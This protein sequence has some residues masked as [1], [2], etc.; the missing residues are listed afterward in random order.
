MKWASWWN[1]HLG[2]MGILGGTGILVEL[3]SWWN[4]HLGGTG[5]LPVSCLFSRGQ[6]AHSTSIHLKTDATPFFCLLS[7]AD[8][9]Q[10]RILAWSR[11]CVDNSRFHSGNVF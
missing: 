9:P 6:D 11:H 7:E 1:G 10:Y 2:E 3:A 5:I 8:F 4:W